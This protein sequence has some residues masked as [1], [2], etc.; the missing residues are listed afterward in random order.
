MLH[1]LAKLWCLLDVERTRPR[2]S[3]SQIVDDAARS[4]GEHNHPVR[5]KDRFRDAVGYEH[6]SLVLFIPHVKQLHIHL[7][8]C[9]GIKRAKGLVHQE[10]RGVVK[11]STTNGNS[12]PHSP[13]Q[14][15]WIFVLES[16]QAEHREKVKSA[17]A[18]VGLIK[19]SDLALYRH[20]P[21]NTP[22]LH[23]EILL[24]HEAKIGVRPLHIVTIDDD[25]PLGKSHEP[26]YRHQKSALA[27]ATWTDQRYKFV[28]GNV[29]GDVG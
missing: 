18:R 10:K 5:E 4:S 20:I 29:E 19:P 26:A 15:V 6:H 2:H 28:C 23:E 13:R 9:H 1:E 16:L 22:P 24:E 21:E 8:T 11:K 27:A 3:Y 12:L 14:L 25:R 17:T 7:F